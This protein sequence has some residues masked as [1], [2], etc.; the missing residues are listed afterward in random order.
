VTRCFR[1]VPTPGSP[2]TVRPRA[3]TV[4]IPTA[5]SSRS[6]GC[7]HERPGASMRRPLRWT[8]STL[9]P[10][11]GGG[12]GCER[13][14]RS[15]P[16]GTRRG[17]DRLPQASSRPAWLDRSR[18]TARR[19]AARPRS[20]E[21]DIAGLADHLPAGAAYAAVRAPIAEGGGY[22][23]FANRGIGRP[24]AESLSETMAGLPPGS[25]RAGLHLAAKRLRGLWTTLR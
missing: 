20:D 4:P 18:C 24:V 22:A 5:T 6:C 8:I 21:A 25:M 12:P 3:S 23:W 2:V 16:T 7:S 14:A 17:R 13:R 19:T 9:L 11:C 1:P 10:N 15:S